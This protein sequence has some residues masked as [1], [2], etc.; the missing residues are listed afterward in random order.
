MSKDRESEFQDRLVEIFR[1]AIK[2]VRFNGVEFAG[3]KRGVP[4]DNREM[5][6]VLFHGGG[7]PFLVLETEERGQTSKAINDPT[8]PDVLGQAI[9]YVYLYKNG[10]VHVPFFGAATPA[11]CVVFRTPED[12]ESFVNRSKV[13]E[14]GYAGVIPFEKE[15]Y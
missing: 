6:I 9:S 1:E 11:L 14:R 12:L 10:G 5:D 2:G 7:L 15:S 8:S 4:V 13:E 3:V